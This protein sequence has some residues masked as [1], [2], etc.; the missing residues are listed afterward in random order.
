MHLLLCRDLNL[1][2][3]TLVATSK[4]SLPLVLKPGALT[5]RKTYQLKLTG[6]YLANPTDT[7]SHIETFTANSMPVGGYLSVTP[8]SGIA[9][10]TK[11]Y[12]SAENWSD[13]DVPLTFGLS[14]LLI[15]LTRYLPSSCLHCIQNSPY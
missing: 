11:F 1:D 10:E 15:S 6:W 9:G 13:E 8:T 7:A 4:N 5:A 14:F 12:I 2:D 3:P